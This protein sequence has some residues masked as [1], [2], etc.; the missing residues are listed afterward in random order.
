MPPLAFWAWTATLTPFRSA[1]PMVASVP[2][3]GTMTPILTG[4]FGIP[5]DPLDPPDPLDEHATSSAVAAVTD[6][7]ASIFPDLFLKRLGP[8]TA[9][10]PSLA[11]V[12]IG[13]RSPAGGSGSLA[14]R[15]C[16]SIRAQDPGLGRG[17]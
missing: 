12:A 11:A 7:Y 15:P 17:S 3:R 9:S 14:A 6:R 5:L 13:E 2:L 4:P 16:W 10:P 1:C 8:C